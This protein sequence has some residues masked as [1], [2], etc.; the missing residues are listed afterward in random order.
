MIYE[1]FEQA[2]EKMGVETFK[3]LS[4][5]LDLLIIAK[6]LKTASPVLLTKFYNC[7]PAAD[8]EKIK[9]LIVGLG[10][11]QLKEVEKSQKFILDILKDKT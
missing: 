1:E 7:I 10:V 8:A 6:S 3:V 4:Q 9:S 5:K 11:V 2:I